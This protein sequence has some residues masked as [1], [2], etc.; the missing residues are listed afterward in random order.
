MLQNAYLLAKIGADTAENE[1]HFAEIFSRLDLPI[2]CENFEI[3][4]VQKYANLV[5]LEKCCQTHIFLQN[6]VLIQP[7]TSPLKICKFLQNL[8][9]LL[10]LTPTAQGDLAGEQVGA[11]VRARRAGGARRRRP[12][13]AGRRRLG[14]ARWGCRV[15]HGAVSTRFRERKQHVGI[16]FIQQCFFSTFLS[17]TTATR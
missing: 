3:P 12:G 16:V 17:G 4:A 6:F 7:R 5:E 13:V 2:F 14:F 9:I 1:Q 8:P 10:T 11:G 15:F